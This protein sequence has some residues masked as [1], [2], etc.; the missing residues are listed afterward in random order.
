MVLF[1]WVL[2]EAII[3]LQE[4]FDELEDV[5]MLYNTLSLDM[6]DALEDLVSIV[7]PGLVKHTRLKSQGMRTLQSFKL[8]TSF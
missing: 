8:V 5:D 1:F 4:D 7:P 6:V 2:I 3:F